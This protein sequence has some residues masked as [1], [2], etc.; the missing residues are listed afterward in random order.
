MIANRA[1][2][3]LTN[4]TI[5]SAI[6]ALF[7]GS[8]FAKASLPQ[9]YRLANPLAGTPSRIVS[10]APGITE[11]L[12]ALGLG[13]RVVGVT[14]FCTFPAEVAELPRAGGHLDPNLEAILRLRPDLVVVLDEQR[15]LAET[16]DKLA[17]R[18]LIV[19]DDTIEQVLDT[20][21]TLGEHCNAT[22]QATALVDSLQSRMQA[23]ENRTTGRSRPSVLIVLDRSLGT[24]TIEDTFVAGRDDYFESLITMAGGRN[25]YRGP[26]I[27]YPVVSIEG[28][29]RM[30]PDVIIDLAAGWAGHR[31]EQA[32]ADWRHFLQVAAVRHNR[33]HALT[34]D[35]ATI[36]GPRFILLLEALAERI[37]AE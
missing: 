21:T 9:P 13:E 6:I 24:G 30:A 33:I 35:Y 10:M 26:A 32:L 25:A 18:T 31:S 16:L 3:T 2:P 11:T 19:G 1:R 5:A 7:V 22:E 36:P 29:I 20:I 23:I 8:W 37:H 12:F 27:P 34:A 15:D 17:V 28:I 4:A 14:R